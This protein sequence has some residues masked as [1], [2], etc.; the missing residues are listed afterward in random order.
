MI[1]KWVKQFNKIYI[2][3]PT[4]AEDDVWSSLD[5]YVHNGKVKILDSV[6]ENILKRI[7]NECRAYKRDNK[8]NRKQTLI[9]FD[10]CYGQEGFTTY[11]GKGVINQLTTKGNHSDISTICVVQRL[12]YCT[13]TIRANAECIITFSPEGEDDRKLLFK[14]YGVGTFQSFGKM[15]EHSTKEPYTTFMINRQGPGASRYFHNFKLIKN[16][17]N[18]EHTQ[19]KKRRV[20]AY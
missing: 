14:Q 6:D 20:Q 1:A 19:N 10:D 11:S 17:E 15:I 9:Y 5:E 12:V 18:I 16:P 3:C 4:Y 13:P 8:Q 7:W 2:V